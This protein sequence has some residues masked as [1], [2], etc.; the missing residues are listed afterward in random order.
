MKRTLDEMTPNSEFKFWGIVISRF[1][2]EKPR[3]E[4]A[5]K[6]SCSESY[7]TQVLNKFHDD[8]GY[9]EKSSIQRRA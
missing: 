7:V 2:W 1:V 3:S 6:F 9:I 8:G 4:V 5:E